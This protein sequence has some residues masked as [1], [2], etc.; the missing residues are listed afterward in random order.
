MHPE[1]PR[2]RTI[3]LLLALCALTGVSSAQTREH[4]STLPA[5]YSTDLVSRNAELTF[6][7]AV[8]A[9]DGVDQAIN[10]I[11]LD[12]RRAGDRTS[13]AVRIAKLALFDAPVVA[14]FVGLHHEGGHISRSREKNFPYSFRVI[15]GPWSRHRFELIAV[16]SGI[17]DD[18]GAQ[19]GGFEAARY[20]KDRTEARYWSKDRISPGHALVSIV[21]ALDLPVYALHN[22]A[23]GQFEDGFPLGD[24]AAVLSILQT[25]KLLAGEPYILDPER[26]RM[27]TRA[28]LNFADASLWALVYG[29]LGDHVWKGDDGVRVRW[30]RLRGVELLPS[31]RYELTANA[32]EYHLRSQFRTARFAGLGY[33]RWSER[34]DDARQFGIGGSIA[35][36]RSARVMPRLDLDAWSHTRD[37]TGLHGAMTLEVAAPNW[38]NAAL[39][40]AIGAKSSGHVAALPLDSGG[41]VSAGVV[42]TVW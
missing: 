4:Q 17:F 29:V 31:V 26:R 30:L 13:R 18:L 41:Y 7:A 16:D 6:A 15:G 39:T 24:A 20:L 21:S 40:V 19:A 33:V 9:T 10:A 32:P 5:V 25:K 12:D 27:R 42:F 36:R 1:A 22:L 8:L 11:W 14:F 23:P 34:V 28:L 3:A 38:S 35:P 37:G 2:S